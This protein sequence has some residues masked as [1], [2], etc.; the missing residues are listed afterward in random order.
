MSTSSSIAPDASRRAS[1]LTPFVGRARLSFVRR[2]ASCALPRLFP[3]RRPSLVLCTRSGA[4]REFPLERSGGAGGSPQGAAARDR[5]G[6]FLRTALSQ[7]FALRV[8]SRSLPLYACKKGREMLKIFIVL[9]RRSPAQ[10]RRDG[11]NSRNVTP[12]RAD[13]GRRYQGLPHRRERAGELD[14]GG[15]PAPALPLFFALR[16][17]V[18]IKGCFSLRT[19]QSGRSPS[20]C[21]TRSCARP[22]RQA[23][24][25]VTILPSLA[26]VL[27]LFVKQLLRGPLC[28]ATLSRSTWPRSSASRGSRAPKSRGGSSTAA[29]STSRSASRSCRRPSSSPT[30]SR[31]PPPPS[32]PY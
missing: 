32:L 19:P 10:S 18:N 4:R 26:A 2:N 20:G 12:P 29:R 22:Q 11:S 30:S 25:P 9:L 5:Q 13:R 7:Q 15:L 27:S 24:R 1:S 3:H 16:L 6:A 17:F 23:P 21:S 28:K 8:L 14:E 31:P